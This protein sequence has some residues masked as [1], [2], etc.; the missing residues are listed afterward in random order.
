MTGLAVVGGLAAV[1]GIALLVPRLLRSRPRRATAAVE[2]PPDPAPVADSVEFHGIAGVAEPQAPP[3]TPVVIT[4]VVE[5]VDEGDG[6]VVV[7]HGDERAHRRVKQVHVHAKELPATLPDAALIAL[8]ELVRDPAEP[9]LNTR[10]R[11]ELPE[12]GGPLTAVAVIGTGGELH[13]R[14]PLPRL[15]RSSPDLAAKFAE[16]IGHSPV[17]AALDAAVTAA[18]RGMNGVTL[19]HDERAAERPPHRR[20]RRSSS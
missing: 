9:A 4:V 14:L 7:L 12:T 16:S 1:L 11:R 18:L 19:L 15:L 8:R 2:P 6:D 10:F 17:L 5:A 13:V 3:E 20:P